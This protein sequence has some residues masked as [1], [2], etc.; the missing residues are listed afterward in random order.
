MVV[1]AAIVWGDIVVIE[2]EALL[3]CYK[4]ASGHCSEECTTYVS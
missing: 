1:D 3:Y 2:E 4:S